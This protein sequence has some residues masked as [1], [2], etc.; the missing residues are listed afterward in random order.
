V[1]QLDQPHLD[2]VE[3][4]VQP[5]PD[6]AALRLPFAALVAIY[7]ARTDRAW[8]LPVA[9][10]LALPLLWVHGLAILVAITPLWR[11]QA[12]RRA[13]VA[14]ETARAADVSGVAA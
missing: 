8:L 6:P 4:G 7:A 14:A 2:R 13:A 10:T 3:P 9:A 1:V 12:R 11:L 5:H